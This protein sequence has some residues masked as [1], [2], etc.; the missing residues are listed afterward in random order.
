MSHGW[1]GRLLLEREC[2]CSRLWGSFLDGAVCRGTVKLSL[3]RGYPCRWSWDSFLVEVICTGTR[4]LSLEWEH[5]C[6]RPWDFSL[7][8]AVCSV[9]DFPY[10]NY[11]SVDFGDLLCSW[12][13]KEYDKTSM[14]NKPYQSDIMAW[15][16]YEGSEKLNKLRNEVM[17]VVVARGIPI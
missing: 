1:V 7:I 4:E 15:T 13:F 5:F 6:G 12:T 3:D 14:A 2:S 9:W 8:G 11:I 16:L 10:N 17:N